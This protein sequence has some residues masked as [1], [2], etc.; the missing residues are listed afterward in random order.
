MAALRIQRWALKPLILGAYEYHNAYRPGKEQANADAL[1]RLPLQQNIAVPLP[2]DLFLLREHLE[3]QSP[4]TA[5]Q[6]R[7]WTDRD[8]ILAQ[9]RRAILQGPWDVGNSKALQLYVRKKDKL[10]VLDGCLLWGARVAIPPPGREVVMDRLHDSHP[11]I[12]KMRGLARSYVWWPDMSKALK[13]KLIVRNAWS[14][15]LH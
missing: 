4:I 14:H 1:S 9:V 10:S 7:R 5:D 8:L 12:V 11:G 15:G 13:G 2:G 6:I 3:T